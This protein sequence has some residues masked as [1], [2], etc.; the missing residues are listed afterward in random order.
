M[1]FW[2]R[3]RQTGKREGN[4]PP[5]PCPTNNLVPNEYG[6][7]GSVR[8]TRRSARATILRNGGNTSRG[9]RYPAHSVMVGNRGPVV[10]KMFVA[11]FPRS[12]ARNPWG[13]GRG[14]KGCPLGTNPHARRRRPGSPRLAARLLRRPQEDPPRGSSPPEDLLRALGFAS[15]TTDGGRRAPLLGPPECRLTAAG[16]A[17]PFHRS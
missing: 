5:P 2:R 10:V 14:G 6:L 4:T 12:T 15:G 16:K 3:C 13:G 11:P 1:P 9:T 8:W 17:T 7:N